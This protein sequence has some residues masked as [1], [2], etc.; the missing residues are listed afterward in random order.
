MCNDDWVNL[1]MAD[2]SKVVDLL[3]L[4]HQPPP[5][6][7]HLHL[8]WTVRQHRS[9]SSTRASPNTPLS[10][11]GATSASGGAVDGCEDSCH[12]TKHAQSSRSKI[13]NPSN[14]TT[15]KK[16]RRK[17]TLAELK[18]DEKLLLQERKSL[19]NLDLESRHNSKSATTTFDVSEKAFL[20]S[21][22][23]EAQC[24]PSSSVSGKKLTL[25]VLDDDAPVPASNASSKAQEIRN[26]ESIFVF[27]DLNLPVEDDLH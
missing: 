3:L 20:D 6:A 24:H 4:L 14:T 13:A 22:F 26:Q 21:K 25:K 10:W 7:P 11:S 1:A 8:H 9:R 27:P 19:K 18:E 5:P 15:V 17:K 16:S 23:L 2:D 12:P